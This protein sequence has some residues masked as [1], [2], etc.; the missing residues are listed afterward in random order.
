MT[1]AASGTMLE[2]EDDGNSQRQGHGKTDEAE[3][4]VT[5]YSAVKLQVCLLLKMANCLATL[6]F[7]GAESG[8]ASLPPARQ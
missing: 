8:Q 6:L 2:A 5:T 4:K 1:P 7:H 3:P